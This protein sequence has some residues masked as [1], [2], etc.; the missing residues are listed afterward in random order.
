ML[1]F[2]TI[3]SKNIKKICQAYRYCDYRIS[4]YSLGMKLM[5]K[6]YLHPEVAFSNGCVIVKNNFKG[7]TRFDYPLPCEEDSDIEGALSQ[8]EHYC[9]EHY[10]PMIFCAVPE[11]QL[12]TL[13]SR[14]RSLQTESSVFDDDYIYRADDLSQFAGKHYSGQRNH[15]NRFRNTYPEAEWHILTETDIPLLHRFFERFSYNSAQ[16]S[17][18]AAAELKYARNLLLKKN[19]FWACAGCMKYHGEIIS[20]S[21]GEICGDTMIIH[22]EKALHEYEGIYPATVQAFTSCFCNG[23]RYINREEDAGDRG[24][25]R[26]KLQYRP[27]FML[28]KYNVYVHTELNVWNTIPEISTTHLTLSAIDET[29]KTSYNHLCL[30]D[31]RN[32]YWGYDYRLDCPCPDENYFINVT[33]EDFQSKTAVNWGIHSDGKFIGEILL[34]DFDYHGGAQV[35]IRLLKGYEGKG[36]ARE[37]LEAVINE[38]LYS[39]R[40]S[41]IHAKCYLENTK[42]LKLLSSC[43]PKSG[44]DDT[45][46]YFESRI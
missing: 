5:W 43:M 34:Y 23:V 18:E 13:A 38:G 28:R 20:V 33:K 8:I 35:G 14:Y 21:L 4:D 32:R 39:L 10:I 30:D 42:S 3:N 45:Y 41:V 26:S 27:K 16:K 46:V 37:A 36:F 31:E 17:K 6:N 2:T 29:D 22:I 12:S 44:K 19:L 1:N 40:L 24:L 7:A 25:R 15:I 11:S 9:M